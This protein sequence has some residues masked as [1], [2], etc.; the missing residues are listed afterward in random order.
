MFRER[1][2]SGLFLIATLI[3]DLV[4]LTITSADSLAAMIK[5][6]LVLGQLAALAV[7]AVRGQSHRLARI[8]FLVVGTGLLTY[9]V[10]DGSRQQGVWL[11]FNTLYVVGIVLVTGITDVMRY[12]FGM[13]SVKRYTKEHWRVP[14]IEFFGW[15]IAVAIISFG[16][17][18]MEFVFLTEEVLL[19]VLAFVCTPFLMALLVWRDLRDLHRNGALLILVT[20]LVA[21]AYLTSRRPTAWAVTMAQTGYLTLWLATLGMDDVRSQSIRL[22][23]DLQ[24]ELDQSPPMS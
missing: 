5:L 12:R 24:Q 10:V 6:G 19:I 21:A 8:S 9:L 23:D 13:N 15:T 20:A 1:P 7:G 16:A 22:Q 4:L 3:V 2:I 17:R 18:Y 14:L 11:A